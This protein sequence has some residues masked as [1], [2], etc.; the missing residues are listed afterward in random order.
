MQTLKIRGAK[1]KFPQYFRVA[2]YNIVNNP[3][4]PLKLRIEALL[5][6][7]SPQIQIGFGVAAVNRQRRVPLNRRR[8]LSSYHGFN[9]GGDTFK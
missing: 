5:S 3:S 7:V 4:F 1:Y 9:D 6:T 2:M 8:P